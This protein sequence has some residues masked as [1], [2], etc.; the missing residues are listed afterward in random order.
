MAIASSLPTRRRFGDNGRRRFE[1]STA[2]IM[3]YLIIGF[4][5]GSFG[6]YVFMGKFS[7]HF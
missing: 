2:K 7:D 4:L 5:I 1:T 3:A 6:G